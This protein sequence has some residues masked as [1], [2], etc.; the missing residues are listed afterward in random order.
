M[1][2]DRDYLRVRVHR[3]LARFRSFYTK[4]EGRARASGAAR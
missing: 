4:R 1:E 2:I 3:A